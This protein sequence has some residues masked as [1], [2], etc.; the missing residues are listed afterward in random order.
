MDFAF[1]G[2][3][4]TRCVPFPVFGYVRRGFSPE[5]FFSSSFFSEPKNSLWNKVVNLEGMT[6]VKAVISIP[7][8]RSLAEALS[9]TYK[10]GFLV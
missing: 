2:K 7:C 5:V 1:S 4:K 8:S 3:R 9:A 10:S 6:T